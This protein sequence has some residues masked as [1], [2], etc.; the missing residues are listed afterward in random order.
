MFGKPSLDLTDRQTHS[1]V[2]EGVINGPKQSGVAERSD[3]DDWLPFV[4]HITVE[5]LSINY[6]QRYISE[7]VWIK[8]YMMFLNYTRAISTKLFLCRRR[9]EVIVI[10]YARDSRISES[11]GRMLLTSYERNKE[12]LVHNEIDLARQFLRVWEKRE[13]MVESAFVEWNK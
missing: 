8:I 13:L 7:M 5:K 12:I 1:C 4:F 9:I 11:S 6:K 3:A 2:Y 10:R